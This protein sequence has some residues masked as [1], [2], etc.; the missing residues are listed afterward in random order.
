MKNREISKQSWTVKIGGRRC[1]IC[2][3]RPAGCYMVVRQEQIVAKDCVC[4]GCFEY[5]RVLFGEQQVRSVSL[6]EF[7]ETVEAWKKV[8]KT[9]SGRSKVNK[10]EKS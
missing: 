4:L 7:R 5:C 2:E 8:S 10:Y 9:V 1:G 3:R 6:P